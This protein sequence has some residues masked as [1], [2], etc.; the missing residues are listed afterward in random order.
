M[1]VII[2]FIL[3]TCVIISV[4]YDPVAA[5][6]EKYMFNFN[7]KNYELEEKGAVDRSAVWVGQTSIF[8][9][10]ENPQDKYREQMDLVRRAVELSWQRYSLLKFEGWGRCVDSGPGIRVL[11]SD[12]GPRVREF[13]RRLDGLRAGMILNF[14]FKQWAPGCQG[15]SKMDWIGRIAVHEFGHGI[16]FRHEQ[17]R[18]DTPSWC[19]PLKTGPDPDSH[20]TQWDEKSIMNYCWCSSGYDLSALDR[21]AV[22][23]VYGA[24]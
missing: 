6:D 23:R 22:A 3:I 18:D 2:K 7:G 12:E 16:G 4:E 19:Q 1:Q 10:W 24:P 9:C 14:E 8:V 11:I 5:F 13:G 15:G 21:A 17:D 20:I